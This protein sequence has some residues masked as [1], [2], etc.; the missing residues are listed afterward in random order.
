MKHLLFDSVFSQSKM[1]L[2]KGIDGI[3]LLTDFDGTFKTLYDKSEAVHLPYAIDW[4]GIWSGKR[5]RTDDVT[6][7]NIK[8]MYYGLTK[9]EMA[10]NLYSAISNASRFDPSYG[11][12]HASNTNFDEITFKQHSESSNEILSAFTEL[13]NDAVS[14]FPN[15]EPP[16]RIAFENLWW[17]GL[18]LLDNSD[19]RYLSDRIEFENW[20]ICLDTGHLL[21]ATESSV[22]EEKAVELLDSITDGYSKDLMDSIVTIH[23]H[24]NTSAEFM[25][26]L[27]AP[28]GF[29]D[30][31]HMD[32]YTTSY[33]FISQMDEHRPFT[34]KRIVDIV[35]KISPEFINHEMDSPDVSKRIDNFFIQRSL[36]P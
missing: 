25:K 14:R 3:E 19:Y 23:L 6:D 13:V 36:F 11:V 29:Y 31:G 12:L 33:K 15:G 7:H 2:Q 16:F 26:N 35:N 21:V 34:D 4:Y 20:G 30:L 17:P 27:E 18:R 24:L 22:S 32:R 9:E 1:I 10:E 28:E 8:Y 5:E